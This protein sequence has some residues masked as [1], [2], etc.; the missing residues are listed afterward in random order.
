MDNRVEIFFK[1]REYDMGKGILLRKWCSDNGVNSPF[2]TRG[3]QREGEI[4]MG[5]MLI[6]G[7]EKK[8]RTLPDVFDWIS[9]PVQAGKL[10]LVED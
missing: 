1:V 5:S 10:Q 4:R 8:L 6:L 3:V 2:V 9:H 7:D